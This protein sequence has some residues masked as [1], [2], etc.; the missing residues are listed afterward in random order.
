MSLPNFAPELESLLKTAVDKTT[1]E[2]DEPRTEEEH[3]KPLS[4]AVK[5][6]L[7]YGAGAGVGFGG[8]MLLDKVYNHYTGKNAPFLVPATAIAAGLGGNYL[9]NKWKATERE[10]IQQNAFQGK[11]DGTG[12]RPSR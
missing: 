4:S 3:D 8:G 5:N 11:R 7:A 10:R 6:T 1:V 2:S 12:G 9:Y